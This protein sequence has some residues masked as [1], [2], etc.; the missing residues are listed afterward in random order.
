MGRLQRRDPW[1]GS[2]G[3]LVVLCRLLV[4]LAWGCG[5]APSW[6]FQEREAAQLLCALYNN[7]RFSA[8]KEQV[9]GR[10]GFLWVEHLPGMHEALGS[11]PST[12]KSQCVCCRVRSRSAWAASLGQPGLHKTLFQNQK[13]P[14]RE[15]QVCACLSRPS[16][17]PPL[18]GQEHGWWA[19]GLAALLLSRGRASL[20]AVLALRALCLARAPQELTVPSPSGQR[21]SDP[22][23]GCGEGHDL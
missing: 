4:P 14:E 17:P 9:Q 11:I 23:G 20:T 7:S 5:R 22:G 3:W 16:P 21:T 18:S 13:S 2:Q 8:S 15:M 19:L 1:S 12:N 6:C 10:A